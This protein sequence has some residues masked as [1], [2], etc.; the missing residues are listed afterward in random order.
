MKIITT[1]VFHCEN[2]D[3]YTDAMLAIDNELADI[4]DMNEI[5]NDTT[6]MEVHEDKTN[7]IITTVTVYER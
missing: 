3:E 2:E 4:E 6:S 1:S 5:C 7:L